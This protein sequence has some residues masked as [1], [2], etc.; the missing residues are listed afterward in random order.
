MIARL[1]RAGLWAVCLTSMTTALV[2]P[3]QDPW[4]QQPKNISAYAPGDTIRARQV[5]NELEPYT[6]VGMPISVESV[7]QYLYRTTDSVGKPIAAAATLIV[8]HNSD[9]SKLL[10][11]ET[12]YDANN[13]DCSPSYTLR[14]GSSHGNGDLMPNMTQPMDLAFLSAAL[15][16]GWWVITSDYEGLDAQFA[17]GYLA[18][19]ATLDSV[20]VALREA[21]ALG[22]SHDARYAMWGYSGGALACEWAAELQPSYAPEL[23]F[24]G[25]AIGGLLPNLTSAIETINMG[26]FSGAAFVIMIGVAKAYEELHGWLGENLIEASRHQFYGSADSCVLGEF[27][28]GMLND[29][30]RYFSRGKASFAD[31]VPS[32]ILDSAGQMGS[33]GVPRMPMYVYKGALDEISPIADTDELVHGYCNESVSIEYHRILAAEHLTTAVFGSVNA[34]Q[35][36]SDRLAG[37]AVAN[38]D[39]CRTTTVPLM[40]LKGKAISYL[41]SEAVGTL[42][43]VIG[44]RLNSWPSIRA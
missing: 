44:G 37:H 39:S 16:Q 12:F 13:P 40:D 9:P 24:E 26:P 41:G 28:G 10:A 6:P 15:E 19:Y 33:A 8:P 29:I 17:A 4:Y 20:R 30:F 35:W 32:S 25:A 43:S 36:L 27:A 22:L 7:H 14:H 31:P 23:R 18:G 42:T 21:P 3:S 1:L 5:A 2:P 11:Y 38:P 34:L